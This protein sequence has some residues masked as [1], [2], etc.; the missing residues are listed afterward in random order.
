MRRVQVSAGGACDMSSQVICLKRVNRGIFGQET[1][2]CDI[3]YCMCCTGEL[4]K[5]GS[6]VKSTV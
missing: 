2:R 4:T 6:Y 1:Q 5:K 3:S